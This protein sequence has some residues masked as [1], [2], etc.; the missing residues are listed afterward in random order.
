LLLHSRD[1]QKKKKEQKYLNFTI[2]LVLC[3]L[4]FLVGH[5]SRVQQC[6]LTTQEKAQQLHLL[7]A[8]GKVEFS[9]AAMMEFALPICAARFGARIVSMK[10]SQRL[11]RSKV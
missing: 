4:D 2:Y 3:S 9:A 11:W 5:V 7:G 6:L 1:F 10:Y 8:I